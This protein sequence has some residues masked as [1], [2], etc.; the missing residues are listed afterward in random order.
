MHS[1][2]RTMLAKFGFADLDKRNPLHDLACQYLIQP[3]VMTTFAEVT[4]NETS[5]EDYTVNSWERR[6]G[7]RTRVVDNVEGWI[8]IPLNKGGGQYKTTVGFIDVIL[9]C[10]CVLSEQG[11]ASFSHSLRTLQVH[12]FGGLERLTAAL[13]HRLETKGLCAGLRARYVDSTRE[14]L[15]AIVAQAQRVEALCEKEAKARDRGGA[16]QWR[17]AE[18]AAMENVEERKALDA[19]SEIPMLLDL[20]YTTPVHAR[21]TVGWIV[22]V[23]TSWAG[24]GETLRQLNLYREYTSDPFTIASGTPPAG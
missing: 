14:H 24:V 6:I 5:K 1:F 21:Q 4:L 18:I 8:E 23:K 16:K 12:L 22:E 19:L 3:E 11:I 10:S 2:D 7:E 13:D 20:G 17:L 15:T 9:K